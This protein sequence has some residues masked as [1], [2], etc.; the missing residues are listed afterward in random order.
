MVN[1]HEK[2]Q[3]YT[4]KE[5]R[6]KIELQRVELI[7]T[8]QKYGLSSE[9]TLRKSQELDILLSLC[10]ACCPREARQSSKKA[11]SC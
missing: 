4:P 2:L 5:L 8:G 11:S 10:Q 3:L 7:E 6:Q 9:R 1:E